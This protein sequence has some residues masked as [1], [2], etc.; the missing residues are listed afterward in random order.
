[1]LFLHCRTLS[2]EIITTT[3]ATQ[4]ASAVNG[5][6]PSPLCQSRDI[7]FLLSITRIKI[8]LASLGKADAPRQMPQCLN[9]NIVDI[10]G[11]MLVDDIDNVNKHSAAEFPKDM[12]VSLQHSPSN[13]KGL[14]IHLGA[15]L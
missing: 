7:K 5:S 14:L 6:S 1:M 9:I 15:A 8:M 13:I 4:A 10:V 11:T 3:P 12:A 2:L